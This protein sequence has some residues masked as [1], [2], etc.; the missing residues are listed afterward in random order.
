[1]KDRLRSIETARIMSL[2]ALI[3]I[4][5]SHK[6]LWNTVLS[7]WNYIQFISL[8]TL[9]QQ[10]D[11]SWLWLLRMPIRLRSE[12]DSKRPW[13]PRWETEPIAWRALPER[14][15]M[16]WWLQSRRIV[17]IPF[18]APTRPQA[19][20]RIHIELQGCVVYIYHIDFMW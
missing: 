6:L 9:E 17:E 1:M 5:L 15:K 19:F 16:P 8:R 11:P 7:N 13:L 10:S 2:Q 14:S 12:C 18:T 20:G 3:D 4:P